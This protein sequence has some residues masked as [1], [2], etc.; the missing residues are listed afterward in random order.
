M[1]RVLLG[2]TGGIAAYKTPDLVRL[3]AK[4]GI[5]TVCV[6]TK[7]AGEFVA[8]LALRTV[9]GNPVYQD[10]FFESKNPGEKVTHVGLAQN[11]DLIVIAPAT[12]NIIGKIACGIADDLLTTVVMAAGCKVL[13]APAMNTKMWENPIVKENV[14]KLSKLG[15]VFTGPGS[16]ELACGDYG[17]GRMESTENIFKQAALMLKKK[18]R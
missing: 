5:E 11:A 4:S 6:M 3:F 2:I 18:D 1:A 7:E 15:Y 17:S 13:L 16:G 14:K 10:L 12:A 9:S 8:P